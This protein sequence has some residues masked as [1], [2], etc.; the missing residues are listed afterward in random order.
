MQMT[1]ILTFQTA[2]RFKFKYS[3]PV[4]AGV[5][6][7]VGLEARRLGNTGWPA[8]DQANAALPAVPDG[9]TEWFIFEGAF[10]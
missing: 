8:I 7:A 10:E 6:N 2:N 5:R 1:M 9:E 4:F 3:V